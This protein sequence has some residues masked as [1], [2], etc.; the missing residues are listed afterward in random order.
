MRGKR[1]TKADAWTD[2][3]W[4]ELRRLKRKAGREELI[5]RMDACSE[6]ERG[7]P[8]KDFFNSFSVNDGPQGYYTVRFHVS[9]AARQF[10]VIVRKERKAIPDHVKSATLHQT[11]REVA[12]YAWTELAADPRRLGVDIDAT[13]IK[14]VR[15]VR[16][17][18][19]KR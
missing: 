3:D 16:R 4:R 5:R 19:A 1:A 6:P 7:A 13:A 18:K 2:R 15:E 8:K 17:L 10:V 11:M 12:E 14:L 9:N